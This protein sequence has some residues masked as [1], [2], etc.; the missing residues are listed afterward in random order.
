MRGNYN[1]EIV[2]CSTKRFPYLKISTD[3]LAYINSYACSLIDKEYK[4]VRIGISDLGEIALDFN[5]REGWV[6]SKKSKWGNC[7]SFSCRKFKKYAG[8]YHIKKEGTML[9]T[10]LEPKELI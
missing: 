10:D 7:K 2:Q 9:I 1:F 8:L 6:V 3:G 5:D 4:Y